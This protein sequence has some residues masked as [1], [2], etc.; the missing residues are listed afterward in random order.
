MSTKPTCAVISTWCIECGIAGFAHKMVPALEEHFDV[1]VFALNQSIIKPVEKKIVKLGNDHITE[2]CEE[3]KDFDFV[4]IQ[5]E[6][7]I[8]GSSPKIIFKRIN[9]I[10]KASKKFYV[11]F[12]TVRQDAGFRNRTFLRNL[13]S[14][15]PTRALDYWNDTALTNNY[16]KMYRKFNKGLDNAFCL[17]HTRSAQKFINLRYPNIKTMDYPL[18]FISDDDKQRYKESQEADNQWLKKKYNIPQD[19]ILVSCFGFISKYKNFE[20]V[21]EAIYRLPENYHLMIFG[22][23]HPNEVTVGNSFNK[24]LNDLLGL[25]ERKSLDIPQILTEI[26]ESERNLTLDVSGMLSSG[27]GTNKVKKPKVT[28]GGSLDDDDFERAINGSEINVFSYLEVGQT[29]SGPIA[30][31]LDLSKKTIATYNKC[32]G[33]L[34]KYAPAAYTQYDIGNY[35]QLASYIE[36]LTESNQHAEALERYKEDFNVEDRADKIYKKYLELS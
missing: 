23:T 7:G 8:F 26:M 14:K 12:H 21:I 36:N 9:M 16:G 28:F 13:I 2:I 11:T 5:F 32:F 4:N 25:I 10:I 6:P 19:K 31:S 29:S 1:K 3:I 34:A 33:Q 18:V 20:T 15:R 17:Y 35:Q 30:L 22:A 27:A 24:Y